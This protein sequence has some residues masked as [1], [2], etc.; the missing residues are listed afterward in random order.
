MITIQKVRS[1]VPKQKL[2][3]NDNDALKPLLSN[4]AC[5]FFLENHGSCIKWD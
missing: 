4:T 5:K 3:I 2:N 1:K